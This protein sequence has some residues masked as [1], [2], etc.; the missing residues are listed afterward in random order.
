[1]NENHHHK[2]TYNKLSTLNAIE[3]CIYRKL[4]LIAFRKQTPA[5]GRGADTSAVLQTSTDEI[6][7]LHADVATPTTTC[8]ICQQTLSDMHAQLLRI[9]HYYRSRF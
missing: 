6:Y 2:T 4:Q 5:V 7:C 9:L 1:M 3:S 8:S